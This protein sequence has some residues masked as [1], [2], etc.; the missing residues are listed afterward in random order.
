MPKETIISY[1]VYENYTAF[2][3][4]FPANPVLEYVKCSKNF[5]GVPGG[6]V[7]ILTMHQDIEDPILI[8]LPWSTEI[9]MYISKNSV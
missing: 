8:E 3:K 1:D 2:V 7:H 6:F 9:E 5:A 4:D